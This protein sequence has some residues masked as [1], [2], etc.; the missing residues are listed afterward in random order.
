M[1]H[2]ELTVVLDPTLGE[3]GIGRQ[4]ERVKNAIE[5][6]GGKLVKEDRWGLRNLAYRIARQTQGHYTVMEW[7]GPASLVTELDRSLRLEES[8]LRHLII[9]FDAKTLALREEQAR[10]RAAAVDEPVREGKRFDEDEDEE[11]EKE[12]EEEIPRRR[13]RSREDAGKEE[14]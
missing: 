12:N 7:E 14:R 1:R 8:V 13:S 10:R 6:Q 5:G 2:Y 4:L 9:H 11:E 3:D